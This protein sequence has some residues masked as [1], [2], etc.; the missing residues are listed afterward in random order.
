[1]STVPDLD[2][3]FPR[4]HGPDSNGRIV[5]GRLITGRTVLTPF[6]EVVSLS[7]FVKGF[8]ENTSFLP[9][10]DCPV[11]G[12]MQGGTKC[13]GFLRED[14]IKK[15]RVIETLHGSTHPISSV[16]K[17]APCFQAL[18]KCGFDDLLLKTLSRKTAVSISTPHSVWLVPT[19]FAEAYVDTWI[20]F[21]NSA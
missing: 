8:D 17:I 4:V 9:P 18:H 11:V 15:E 10:P 5:N 2:A 1:M 12:W 16:V 13:S 14:P 7:Y 20:D 21:T 3:R 6:M 19:L